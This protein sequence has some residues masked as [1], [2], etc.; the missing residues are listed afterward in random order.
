MIS[1][2][3]V[4]IGF[5]GPNLLDDVDCQ[6]EAGGR[7]GLLGR[8]G[9]G[10]STL[11]KMLRGE[12]EPDHG[13][14]TRANQ[15]EIAYLQ[16]DVPVAES[17]RVDELVAAG[18]HDKFRQVESEWKGEQ[19]VKQTLSQMDLDGD[20]MF[21]A[22]SSGMKRR[23]LL[24][25]AIVCQPDLLLLD[26][27][28]NHLDI[29]AIR[30]LEDFLLSWR[31]T[32]IF[33]T[34]DRM[35]LRQVATRILEIDRGRV[36]DWSCDYDTFLQRKEQ[37][38][39]AEEKQQAL[40]DKKL[41]QEEAWIRQGIKARRVRNEG[42]VRALKQVVQKLTSIYEEFCG[43][44][45]AKEDYEAALPD[46]ESKLGEVATCEFASLETESVD[47]VSA[48]D[49][50]RQAATEKN[51]V[52]ALEQ[53]ESLVDRVADYLSRLDDMRAK[54]EEFEQVR[55]E[56]DPR[57]ADAS[58]SQFQSLAD[59]DEQIAGMT[60]QMEEA[61]AADNFE[62]ALEIANDLSG[63]VDEKLQRVEEIETAKAEYEAVRAD[64][65]PRLAEASTCEF[66]LLAELDQQIAD[67]T[68]QMEEAAAGDDF[69]QARDIAN[70]LSEK[71]DEKL[72]RAE[73]L[74]TA[75]QEYETGRAALD[76]RLAEASVS[77]HESLA[78]DEER[79]ATLT[80][81][82]EAAVTAGD[83]VVARDKVNELQGLV[84]KNLAD[85]AQLDRK[86]IGSAQ[87]ARAEKK[88]EGLSE[89]ERERFNKLT[90]DAK[91]PE[92][93]DYITKAL[94]SNHSIDDI[95]TFA[96]KI[97]GKDKDWLQNNLKLTG[98]TSGEGIKQQWGHSCNATTAQA[99]RGELDPVYAL[100]LHEEN[101]DLTDA[102]DS[103]G[104]K[105][106]PKLAAD[107]K[108]ALESEYTG[109]FT[110]SHKGE[111]VKRD[112]VATDGSG[113]FADDL[114]NDT[115][116]ST[117]VEYKT[118]QIDN[119]Y[120]FDAAAADVEAG[121]SKGHPVP[122]IVGGAK[123]DTAT[124]GEYSTSHYVMVTGSDPGPPPTW[125]IHDPWYGVTVTHDVQDI[126]D[127]NVNIGGDWQ[128]LAAIENPS[129]KE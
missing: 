107:Q 34:H 16:Q 11:L 17:Q 67:M 123:T 65:D 93:L 74:A 26:E 121:V 2:Q 51:F 44:K 81:E 75:K 33:V 53:L 23:V 54:K 72:Q 77:K 30:W 122:L 31:G 71:V 57:L 56:L 97:N 5:R 9:A 91:S 104:A 106:N 45:A 37:A 78:A 86:I 39:A 14:I 98:N 27:P 101:T 63:K 46:F 47:I 127:G 29:D 105:M 61:A 85:E 12:I 96:K 103:D 21:G 28:T 68:T 90:D 70:N 114:L 50:M 73:E 10:K 59:L 3:N 118:Q 18:L 102:D 84:D 94:A 19:L 24:A 49:N 109:D 69:E 76:P 35:F 22:L 111:A 7:I 58:T 4:S 6:I 92:E 40:F 43:Q 64:L 20:A 112:D 120:D 119:T 42:R 82:M 55:V 126:K 66:Q 128:R 36:F 52:S 1:L 113:R 116:D 129:T 100:Q 89:A 124:T 48:A 99:V 83:F 62:Q 80:T 79:I 108:T 25:R 41:A 15:I 125:T 8:N 32:L 115:S 13:S 88:L 110:G 95:E 87:R 60:T 38:L 117:G